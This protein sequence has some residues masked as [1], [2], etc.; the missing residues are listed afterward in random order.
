MPPELKIAVAVQSDL[1]VW[2]KLNATAFAVSGLTSLLPKL[3]GEP[4]V[5]GSGETYSPMFG[6]PVLVQ[7][8]DHAAIVRA[9]RRARERGLAMSVFTREL[10]T[11]GN[12]VDN[13]AAVRAVGTDDL[14]VV[15]FAVAGGAK[16]VDKAF[17]RLRWHP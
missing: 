9:F 7:T 17:D 5:D 10:F 12:D 14:D 3:L 2:Q 13:R 6:L 4:Y 11:T 16:L 1:E 8:G 15:V